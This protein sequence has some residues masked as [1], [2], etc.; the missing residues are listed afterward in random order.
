[1]SIMTVMGKMDAK[2]MGIT[3]PHE[4]IVIDLEVFFSEPE[5]VGAKKL[6]HSPV[7]MENL[8]VLRRNPFAVL[9][10]LK[11]TDIDT[12][13][14]EL[15]EFKAAGGRTVVDASNKGLGRDPELLRL[16]SA[17][18]GLNIVTGSGY[19][20]E[21]AQTKEA[22]A[23]SVEEIEN[24]I[25]ND[26]ENGIGY[27]GVK[28]GFIGEIGVSHIMYPFEEKSLHAACRAQVRTNAPMT[29][30]IN[31]WSTQ[32]LNAMDI[33]S[34]YKIAPEKVVICHSDVENNEDYIF[35]LLDMG[36]Y[37][38][39][40]NWGKEMFTDIWDCKPGSGRFA[41]D[42]QRAVLTK[43][44]VERGYVNQML[45]STDLCLKSLLHTY[46]GWGYDHV[47]KHIVPMWKELGITDEQVN[48]MLVNNPAR[49]LDF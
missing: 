43:K 45:H 20:V 29:V 26:I 18:T 22:L 31:P 23:L 49:W 8:G 30:H 37:L 14:R 46:G 2:D 6:A 25:V 40:D 4:H 36:V 33:V 5:E 21:G 15:F 28:A 48:Q 44:I 17:R 19:Y 47:L 12:Q 34:S 16:I 3:A 32:G 24:E 9:D 41:T 10:N 11:M 7:A 35:R 38:E 13:V 42:W 39:F 1:M 27:T